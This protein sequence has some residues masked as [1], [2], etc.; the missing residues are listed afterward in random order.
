[1][2]ILPEL[3]RRLLVLPFV[4]LAPF[5]AAAQDGP[6][7]TLD[8]TRI[9]RDVDPIFSDAIAR[10]EIPGAVFLLVQGDRV[11][12]RKAYGYA[13]AAKKTPMDV[14][15]TAIHIC[16]V[17]KIF[18]A[19]A[20]MQLVERGQLDLDA[21]VNRYLKA[22]QVR[23]PFATPLT[24]RH[25]LTHTGGLDD[26][27]FGKLAPTPAELEPLGLHLSRHM[28]PVIDPPGTVSRYSNYGV[29][30]AG[31]LVEVAWGLPFETCVERS[32]FAPLGMG[33][34]SFV[35]PSPLAA[36]LATGHGSRSGKANPQRPL[37]INDA[38]AGSVT[39][40]VDDM[41]RFMVAFLN[42]GRL[43]D[44]VV[45][46]PGSVAAMTSP[47]HRAD[48]RL[49]FSHGLG[50]QIDSKGG[51]TFVGHDGG[52]GGHV[53]RLVLVPEL[54]A[55]FLVYFNRWPVQCIYPLTDK[56]FEH[57]ARP[58][59]SKQWTPKTPGAPDRRLEGLYRNSWYVHDSLF[60][61]LVLLGAAEEKRVSVQDDGTLRVA[62]DLYY[63]VEPLLYR[64][65]DSDRMVAFRAGPGGAVTLYEDATEELHKLRWWE[66]SA[67]SLRLLAA[68]VA[69]LVSAVLAWGGASLWR[70]V[71]RRPSAA[72]LPAA[73]R[74]ARLWT[75]LIVVCL[76]IPV[77][78]AVIQGQPENPEDILIRIQ[79]VWNAILLLLPQIV[80]LLA[81]LSAVAA[82]RSW[83]SRWWGL[84][85]RLHYSLVA[86]ASASL[87]WLLH[88]WN[89]LG[90][91]L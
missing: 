63:P 7:A 85:V 19:V 21:D 9:A 15:R 90:Y 34:A 12:L 25:L 75:V 62:D 50:W 37:L 17:S 24:L 73:A 14:D 65:K 13:D 76:S 79:P 44:A 78:V 70:A 47:Q 68:C 57:F 16:S 26:A 82:V 66:T 1:M 58:G 42:G 23:N 77:A 43:G 69:V 32:V 53:T 72:P 80:A 40:R 31:Y 61:F 11:I 33:T 35:Q 87:V 27:L 41:A 74:R 52:G 28:P 81:V 88:F 71:L 46:E 22:F 3:P 54:K 49:P 30:L 18:T 56:L 5:A 29:A 39:T 60:K 4:I 8:A 84:V 86:L 67:F 36:D 51:R 64:Q 38:P 48:P 83:R 10:G 59:Y 20:V 91:R 2:R 45:L 55:G 89:I 6:A